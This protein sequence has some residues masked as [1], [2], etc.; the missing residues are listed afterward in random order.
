MRKKDRRN[1]S[2]RQFSAPDHTGELDLLS[3]IDIVKT[4]RSS[5]EPERPKAVAASTSSPVGPR[6][7]ATQCAPPYSETC[8]PLTMRLA[9]AARR[10]IEPMLGD[11]PRDWPYEDRVLVWLAPSLRENV[12]AY[13]NLRGPSMELMCHGP[14]LAHLDHVMFRDLRVQ[15]LRVMRAG[16]QMPKERPH[17]NK[18]QRTRHG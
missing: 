5:H 6:L 4:S 11:I 15:I 14:A 13:W 3:F 10:G 8:L 18:L 7:R 1:A 9:R 16:A 2:S 17:N 12:V